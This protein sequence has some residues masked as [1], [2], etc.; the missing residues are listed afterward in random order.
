MSEIVSLNA[1]TGVLI[2]PNDPVQLGR[3][4]WNRIQHSGKKV[5]DDWLVLAIALDVGRQLNITDDGGLNKK[6][7]GQW[8]ISE[9]FSD[10]EGADRSN[11]LWFLDNQESILGLTQITENNPTNIRKAVRRIEKQKQ[12]EDKK[13]EN[14]RISAL[15]IGSHPP[16]I[17]HQD[18]IAF[19]NGIENKSVDLLITDPPYSTDVDSIYAFIDNWVL[20]AIGKIKHTGRAYICIG[21]YPLEIQAY[22]D[23]LLK[24]DEFIVDNPLIWTYRNT[25]GVTPKDK[26]NLNYQMILH[27]Y[28]PDTPPLDTS[29]TNEMFS[30]QDINAPDG[31]QGDRFHTWQK[32]D[33]LANRL[34]RHST[35]PGYCVIDPFACT[36]TFLIAA[37]R[38][39]CDAS[40]CDIEKDAVEI[41]V[42]RGCHNG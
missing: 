11:A 21:A 18:C 10:L 2:D 33:E 14:K 42:T 16:K 12:L 20:K 9:G 35:K 39:G 23:V 3:E 25:L 13:E 34:I 1:S 6:E 4:A 31:R 19:L 5:R 28:Y 32:P 27:L 26:Y 15:E 38:H 22:L 36:G 40:G 29:I 30:V 37:A 41:A 17:H 24:Q 7:F 8:C